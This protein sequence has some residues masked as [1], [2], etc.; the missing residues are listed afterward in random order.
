MGIIVKNAHVSG[1]AIVKC[2]GNALWQLFIL[3]TVS[4]AALALHVS[5]V[6]LIAISEPLSAAI[7]PASIMLAI[8]VVVYIGLYIA[9]LD[10]ITCTCINVRNNTE[11]ERV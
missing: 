9:Y 11:V 8:I 5:T 7:I 2:I 1:T 10:S 4:T 3:I 6:V